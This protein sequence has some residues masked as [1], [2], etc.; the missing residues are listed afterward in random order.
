MVPPFSFSVAK[1]IG[2][3]GQKDKKGGISQ[4]E[5]PPVRNLQAHSLFG[6]GVNDLAVDGN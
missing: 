1:M 3:R 4:P 5:N 2:C 6:S